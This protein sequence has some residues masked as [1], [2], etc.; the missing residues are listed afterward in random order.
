VSD[1][2]RLLAGGATDFELGV[3]RAWET[4]QPSDRAR[5][6]V[7]A[8]AGFG[9]A[10]GLMT[11]ASAASGTAA[12]PNVAAAATAGAKASFVSA[13]VIKWLAIGAV[14]MTVAAGA[15]GYAVRSTSSTPQTSPSSPVSLPVAVAAAPTTAAT[16]PTVPEP[17]ALPRTVA[18]TDLGATAM[19]PR[20][21]GTAVRAREAS[22]LDEEVA[23]LE[24]ARRAVAA[25]DGAS[26]IAAVEAYDTKYPGGS[27]AQ[28]STE[29]RIDALLR[30][31]DRATAEHLASRFISAH[32]SSPYVRRI[33]AL[34]AGSR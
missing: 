16:S 25:G 29:I 11:A 32:P 33:R 31:G 10:A 12:A 6:R 1:P 26:A 19:P 9:V 7:L 8:L 20:T 34:L 14:G 28:E 30:Q 17:A 2:V 18:R 13:A 3:L 22:T 21:N 5:G 4:K 24:R 23:S 15:V 27:L